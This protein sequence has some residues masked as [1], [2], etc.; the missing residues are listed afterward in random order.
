MGLCCSSNSRCEGR[1]L[2]CQ[3]IAEEKRK[4][5]FNIYYALPDLQSKRNYLN[6]YVTQKDCKKQ[7]GAKR[8]HSNQY[9]LTSDEKR[10]AVCKV[11]F[12]STLGISERQVDTML[13]RRILMVFLRERKEAVSLATG[14]SRPKRNPKV[15]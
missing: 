14:R 9:F 8:N 5:I 11:M 4:S 7:T 3:E 1:N 10:H 13:E 2:E 6:Q 12:L 15:Y